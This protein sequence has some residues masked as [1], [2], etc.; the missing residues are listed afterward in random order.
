MRRHLRLTVDRRLNAVDRHQA[1]CG[2][3][4]RRPAIWRRLTG[5]LRGV[6]MGRCPGSGPGWGP[7]GGEIRRI[8]H[9]WRR[10]RCRRHGRIGE[11][12][13]FRDGFGGGLLRRFRNGGALCCVA[14]GRF[15]LL[16]FWRVDRLCCRP[17]RGAR[18]GFDGAAPSQMLPEGLVAPLLA[19]LQHLGGGVQRPQHLLRRETP[20]GYS[21][22]AAMHMISR[23]YGNFSLGSVYPTGWLS[24]LEHEACVA[25]CFALLDNHFDSLR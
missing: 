21:L 20:T 4:L 16:A 22:S 6:R 19:G 15:G 2:H 9:R 14:R 13:W 24:G 7:R 3:L 11:V 5:R 8:R 17:S 12:P 23:R 25:T 18:A 10:R 1:A